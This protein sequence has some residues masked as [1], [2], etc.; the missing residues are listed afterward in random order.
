MTKTSNIIIVIGNIT[1]ILEE[2][3]VKYSEKSLCQTNLISS[4]NSMGAPNQSDTLRLVERGGVG[5]LRQATQSQGARL[6]LGLQDLS[7]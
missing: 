7:H 6:G 4:P 5:G 3:S 2:Y 1:E